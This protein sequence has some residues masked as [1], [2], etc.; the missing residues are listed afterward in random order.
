M[1][2]IGIITYLK[3]QRKQKET[4]LKTDIIISLM[5]KCKSVKNIKK[6]F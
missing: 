5:K 4:M 3:I 1:L 2:K 6:K